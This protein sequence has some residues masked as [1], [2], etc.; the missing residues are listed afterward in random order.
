MTPDAA[1]VCSTWTASALPPA[2]DGLALEPETGPG[3]D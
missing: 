1:F 3:A 2:T